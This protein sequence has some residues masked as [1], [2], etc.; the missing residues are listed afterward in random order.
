MRQVTRRVRERVT[1]RLDE[2]ERIA[3]ELHDTLLQSTQGLILLFQ[4]FAGRLTPPD[5]MRAEMETALDQADRL[6]N[7][8]RTRVH[9]LRATGPDSDITRLIAN[10]GAQLFSDGVPKF[11]LTV[12]G[13]SRMLRQNVTDELY[14]I[15]REALT[16]ARRHASAASVEA[17]LDWGATAFRVRIRDDGRGVEVGLMREG[18]RPGHFGIPGMRGASKSAL[19]NW[20]AQRRGG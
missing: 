19:R 14:R 1:A 11:Q 17:N 2:R 18:V 13:T 3:R 16:N 8:A 10:L 7:E 4:G 5:L 9:D 12:T 6:L 20:E 15:I